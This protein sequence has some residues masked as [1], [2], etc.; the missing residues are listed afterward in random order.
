MTN[1]IT[2]KLLTALTITLLSQPIF[3]TESN[4]SDNC[5]VPKGA[6]TAVLDAVKFTTVWLK[7][8]RDNNSTA[9]SQKHLE[10]Y[11]QESLRENNGTLDVEKFS[12]LWDKAGNNK[13]TT[14]QAHL[15]N[16]LIIIV[17]KATGQITT[18]SK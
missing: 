10:A 16:A 13:N 4:V 3:A 11:I 2:K 9:G 17:D 15:Q 14:D 12:A 7:L 1:S 8:H 6:K 18:N 5:L